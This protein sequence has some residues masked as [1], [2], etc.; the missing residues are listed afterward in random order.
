MPCRAWLLLP[1][2]AARRWPAGGWCAALLACTPGSVLPEGP[3]APGTSWWGGH[4]DPWGP[5]IAGAAAAL[6]MALAAHGLHVRSLVRRGRQREDVLA[7]RTAER[8]RADRHARDV[9]EQLAQVSR[10]ESVGRLATGIA[11]EMNTPLQFVTDN[12]R[13]LAD[14]TAT[15]IERSGQGQPDDGNVAFLAQEIPAAVTESL[16]GLHQVAEIVRALRDYAY[17]G[18]GRSTTDANGLIRTAA[19]VCRNEWKHVARLDL[20]LDPEAGT[21]NCYEGELKHVLVTLIVGAAQAIEAAGQAPDGGLGTICVTTR[22]T[23]TEL[24]VTVED[25]GLGVDE[26]LRTQ[27][28]GRSLACG[29]SLPGRDRRLGLVGAV[30]ARHHGNLD[31][32][33]VPGRGGIAVLR[34]PLTP[35]E[36]G[37]P[38]EPGQPGKP[39]AKVRT[40]DQPNRARP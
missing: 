17:P 33:A 30:V 32:Q 34:L 14:A 21:L 26:G 18:T 23:A 4:W 9:E 5:A 22:R 28:P 31:L 24:V 25:D 37:Q 19:Q 2:A 13:F 39:G 3:S 10:L 36:P 7:A 29:G 8:D 35:P 38:A 11:H 6:A 15:L 27:S 40:P 12:L 20:D 16:E 1:P